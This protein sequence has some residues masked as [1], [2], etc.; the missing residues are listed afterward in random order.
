MNAAQ[1]I[2]EDALFVVSGGARGVTAACVVAIAARYHC[3]F[4]LLGRSPQPQDEPAW[5]DGCEEEM[6]LRRMAAQAL[7][8]S[9]GKSTP[10][11]IQ[12]LVTGLLSGREIQRTLNSVAEAGGQAQYVSADIADADALRATLLPLLRH[13][14][15]VTGI[16]HGAGNLADRTIE[17]KTGQDFDRVFGA[18]VAGLGNLLSC[19]A[20]DDLGYLILF[21]SVA[22]FYGNPGQADYA[23][24]NE[25]LNKLA[26]TLAARHPTCRVVSLDWGPWDGGMVTPA[27]KERF[28]AYGVQVMSITDGAQALLNTLASAHSVPQVLVGD[29]LPKPWSPIRGPLR[30]FRLRR[31]LTLDAN[32]FLRDHVVGKQA[33][34]PMACVVSWIANACEGL[35]PGY[36]AF[37]AEDVHVLKGIVFDDSLA[38]SYVLDLKEVRRD[39]EAGEVVCDGLI[40]SQTPAGQTRYHYRARVAVCCNMHGAPEYDDL[41]LTEN[42]HAIDGALLYRNG[43]LFHGPTFQ[44]VQRVLNISKNK[45]TVRCTAPVLDAVHQGQFPVSTYDPF[46][47][48]TQ[49]QT[50]LIWA[51]AHYDAGALPL[52]VRRGEFFRTIRP[53]STYFASMDVERSSENSLVVNIAVHDER[54]RMYTRV[55]GAEVTISEGLNHLFQEAVAR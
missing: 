11:A 22:G 39:D 53:G 33:V 3:R 48:D 49:F 32:P 17:R 19:V 25:I 20:A 35:F 4:I 37:R 9:N 47:T 24:A 6:E 46:Q 28:A 14:G 52:T 30:A 7:A 40:W 8:G 50:M 18:K 27:L 43:T 38:D 10:Q 29:P 23:M 2:G 26:H 55:S 16:I 1:T 42:E 31:R 45:V 21:S 13:T 5:A 15:P 51:R 36:L 41:Q 34:L 54:G 12:A 44:G